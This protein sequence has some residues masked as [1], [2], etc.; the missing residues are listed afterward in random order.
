MA[1]KLEFFLWGHVKDIV[2]KIPVTSLD[3]LK[4]RIVVAIETVKPQ[5]LEK[6]WKETEHR[7]DILLA[8]EGAHFEIL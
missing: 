5:M 7:L 1:S 8:T 4:L 6:V 3:E 2:C